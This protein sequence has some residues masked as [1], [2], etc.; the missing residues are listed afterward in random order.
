[1]VADP[2]IDSTLLIGWRKGRTI[3]GE[4][5]YSNDSRQMMILTTASSSVL[6]KENEIFIEFTSQTHFSDALKRSEEIWAELYALKH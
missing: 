3:N 1:M 4:E 2:R 6:A 5:S